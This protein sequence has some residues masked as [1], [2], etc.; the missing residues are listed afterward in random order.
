M[1]HRCL[2]GWFLGTKSTRRSAFTALAK[3]LALISGSR[4]FGPLTAKFGFVAK[5]VFS[6]GL[7]M[8][9]GLMVL[10]EE[11]FLCHDPIDGT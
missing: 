3:Y 7:A 8:N 9:S 6:F 11:M 5:A 4:Q 10:A 2:I 1:S